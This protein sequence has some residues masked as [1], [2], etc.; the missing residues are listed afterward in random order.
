MKSNVFFSLNLLDLSVNFLFKIHEWWLGCFELG[1][2]LP[3]AN[4]AHIRVLN[5]IFILRLYLAL[6]LIYSLS[7][8]VVLFY[9][10]LYSLLYMN[11]F[12]A[13][14]SLHKRLLPCKKSHFKA[15]IS[16]LF[17]VSHFSKA[18]AKWTWKISKEIWK[19]TPFF[20]LLVITLLCL[21][22]Y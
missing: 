1:L 7:Y 18:H 21:C 9:L 5:N 20:S 13:N 10:F 12:G 4:V 11:T 8:K 15:C 16:L 3:I 6:Y 2:K 17:C 19:T 22:S 14:W